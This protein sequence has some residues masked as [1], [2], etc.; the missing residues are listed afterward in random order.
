MGGDQAAGLRRLFGQERV[1]IVTFAAG[2]EGVGKTACVANLAAAFAAQ[3]KE[4]LLIDEN[5]HK[6]IASHFAAY[7]RDGNR[8]DLCHVIN[9]EKTLSEVVLSVAPGIRILPV[10]QA[11][12]KL[13]R[14]SPLEQGNLLQ[15]VGGMERPADIILVDATTDHPL[16]FSPLG[17]ATQETVIVLSTGSNA[18]TSAYALIKKVSLGYDR[19][20][21][22]I[23]VNKARNE[24][25]A[26]VIYGNLARVAA[27][28][29]VARLDYL[30]HVPR[31]ERLRQAYR[32]CQPVLALHP[33]TPSAQA[34][35]DLADDML[36]WPTAN[37]EHGG[38]EQF[39]QQLLHLSQRID[40]VEIH[41]G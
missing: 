4:V 1:R 37:L 28:H 36:C 32:F 25:E 3:G 16:G 24:R 6:D 20:N 40:P 2:D 34:F 13:N 14:L 21:F 33:E 29:G 30:G 11:V 23:L 12:Q 35:H 8:Y 27:A 39:V 41:Y 18:I 31:D 19:R 9:G 15:A 10:A 17:L 38:F 22:H 7:S 5:T 26:R